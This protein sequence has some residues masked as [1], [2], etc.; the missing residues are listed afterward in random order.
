MGRF[1]ADPMTLRSNGNKILQNSEE[2]KK[3]VEKTYELKNKLLSSG[4]VAPEA[5]AIGNQIDT[6]RDELNAMGKII[7]DYG[8]FLINASQKVT[9]TQNAIIEDIK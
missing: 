5:R 1:V 8:K 7:S 6:Y 3:D 9:N 2:F 4:Y